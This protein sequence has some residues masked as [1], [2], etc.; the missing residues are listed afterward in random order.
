MEAF[1]FYL[2][3]A[4]LVFW[5]AFGIEL[6]VGNRSIR[7]LKDVPSSKRLPVPR[8][9]IIIP[10]R[11]EEKNIQ[12]ALE[13]VLDQDY[14]NLEIAVIDDRS[15]DQ[16]AAILDRMA[17]AD[18]RLHLVHVTDLPRG[19]LGKN[20]AL[21]LGAQQAT[22]DL[23]LFTD[24]DVVMQPSTVSRAVGYMVEHQLDHVT[25]ASEV[26]MPGTL[27]GM[28]TGAFV[29]FFSVYARP[30][31][32]KDPKSSR[33]IGIGGF[34]LVRA[35]VYR[36]V[37]THQAIAMRPDDDMKLG[38]LIKGHGYRQEMV[39]GKEQTHVEWY[40]SLRELINGLMKN[41]FAGLDYNV[42]AVVAASTAQFLLYGWP[43]LGL[44]LTHGAT[45]ILNGSSVL[46]ML[47]LSWDNA[48]FHNLRRWYGIGF[49][50]ATVLLIYIIWRAMLTTVFNKG[51]N[52][53]GT[54]YS[55]A[56]LR[57]NRV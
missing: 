29:I 23:L 49:P 19:W 32:A 18:P 5:V 38:K 39:F 47:L 33:Y 53:R 30:W 11:N 36:E 48:E 10:A 54:H 14:E 56:E 46:V 43:F 26:R 31:K 8:V 27:L 13:S 6:M 21:Y 20:H 4:T 7:F 1:L 55:L 22:G 15:T 25:L 40:S 2:A 16:T 45:R 42:A 34:N 3:I 44:L 17:Q 50:V 35:D 37:G 9:S 12:E 41:A 24:A 57:A 52:W 51:I 28:F